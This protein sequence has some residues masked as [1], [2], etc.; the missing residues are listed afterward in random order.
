MDKI[1]K[2]VLKN[3]RFSDNWRDELGVF[4]SYYE[5]FATEYGADITLVGKHP[6]FYDLS[7]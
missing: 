3:V 7:A 4:L 2:T 1:V 5:T 6:I